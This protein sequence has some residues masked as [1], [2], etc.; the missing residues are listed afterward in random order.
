MILLLAQGAISFF[1]TGALDINFGI[2]APVF[3][4][5][6]ETSQG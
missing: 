4:V 1:G 3:V 5:S 2:T 6:P